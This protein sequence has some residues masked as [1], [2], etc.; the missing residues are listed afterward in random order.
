MNSDTPKSCHFIQRC[1]LL[2]LF[3]F[4]VDTCSVSSATL[5]ITIVISAVLC[6][7]AI[8]FLVYGNG[9]LANYTVYAQSYLETIKHRNLV[10]DLGKGVKTKAQLTLPAKIYSGN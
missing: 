1:F 3:P 9:N 6:L 7:Y 10:I 2:I 5:R 8:S 4:I